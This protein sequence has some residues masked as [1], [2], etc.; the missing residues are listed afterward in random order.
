MHHPAREFR[1]YAQAL[2]VALVSVLLVLF[3]QAESAKASPLTPIN[4]ICE[5][6]GLGTDSSPYLIT[7]SSHLYESTDCAT[8]SN[9]V[10]KLTDDIP[11]SGTQSPIG[12][13]GS[14]VSQIFSGVFDGN[15]HSITGIDITY[16]S[17]ADLLDF[18]N[19]SNGIGLF[20]G[21]GESTFKDVSFAGSV[22]G[23]SDNDIGG[24]VGYTAVSLSFV[25]VNVAIAVAAPTSSDHIGGFVGHADGSVRFSGSTNQGSV[26]AGD[27]VGGFIGYAANDVLIEDSRND[28]AINGDDR[29]GGFVGYASQDIT[30]SGS[31]NN[32]PIVASGEEVGGFVGFA[33]QDAVLYNVTNLANVTAEEGDIGGFIGEVD[34]VSISN[35]VNAG[36]VSGSYHVG[37]FVGHVD[38]EMI[39]VSSSNSGDI[40]SQGD[41]VGGMAGYAEDATVSGSVNTGA[42]NGFANSSDVGGFVGEVY[43]NLIVINSTNRGAITGY[44]QVGGFVGD[45]DDND[46]L[47]FSSRNFGNI[48]GTGPEHF[49]GFAGYVSNDVDIVLSENHGNIFGGG[50]VGG[51]VGHGSDD[52]DITDS[53]NYGDVTGTESE[54]GGFIGEVDDDLYVY[55]SA[56]Y[57]DVSA[58]F[59]VGGL[60]GF[61]DGTSATIYLDEVLAGGSI[62][63]SYD[64]GGLFGEVSDDVELANALVIASI[65]A[66]QSGTAGFVGRSSHSVEVSNS[67]FAG[68]VPVSSSV[69]AFASILAGSVSAS[70]SFWAL[71]ANSGLLPAPV[72]VTTSLVNSRY[73]APAEA[74]DAAS[75][76]GWDFTSIWAFGDC[77]VNNGLPTLRFAV[78][79]ATSQTQTGACFVADN[80]VPATTYVGPVIQSVTPSVAPEG[81]VQIR[82]ARLDTITRV[83]V[84]GQEVPFTLDASNNLV[85]FVVPKLNPGVYQTVFYSAP[86]QV[87]LTGKITILGTG[88]DITKVNVGSFNG[89]L[90]VYALN[91]DGSRITWKVGGIWG[92]DF[93]VGNQLNRFDRLTP[94]KGVTV[95]VDIYVNGVKRM[96]KNVLTR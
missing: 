61:L 78:P 38:Y 17:G 9:V 71:T 59:R 14:S 84:G 36:R 66:E 13:T 81:T 19:N 68:S 47:V 29:V 23:G 69:G 64:V 54:V 62:A 45:V 11:L 50:E 63:A 57:G 56:N 10:V 70:N 12:F 55:R 92:Q 42:V 41:G 7:D 32:G 31:T 90:V 87:N 35:S 58:S 2:T 83:F 39:V 4:L 34:S 51:F 43:Y 48:T 80:S 3:P 79:S 52:V 76:I 65:A 33:D 21:L 28:G 85:S 30:I 40:F 26:S 49:G 95:K 22:G 16:S 1:G 74:Y 24:I 8:N 73:L 88:E 91:L 96:T 75:Y 82:G 77:S 67:L 15:G 60:V 86:A 20:W 93:A 89:K 53:S 37:G 72:G 46:L 27:D 18:G 44:Q 6:T 5:L 25:N 94:R